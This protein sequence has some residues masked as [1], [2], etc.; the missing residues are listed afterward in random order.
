[1]AVLG[2]AELKKNLR[3]IRAGGQGA[4]RTAAYAGARHLRAAERQAAPRGQNKGYRFIFAKRHRGRPGEAR[5]TVEIAPRA[6]YLK[7]LEVGARPHLL[8]P[9]VRHGIVSRDTGEVLA[10][11]RRVRALAIGKGGGWGSPNAGTATRFRATVQH[12]GIR[13]RRW[14]SSTY[15]REKPNI[16]EAVTAAYRVALNKQVQKRGL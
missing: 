16:L 6:F 14:F 7:I 12:P 11:G 3:S 4:L 8:V 9:R 1:M 2:V 15:E 13:P 10:K 5:S